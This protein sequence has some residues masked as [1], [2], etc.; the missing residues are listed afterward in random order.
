MWY[1]FINFELIALDLNKKLYSSNTVFLY[2][3]CHGKI[4]RLKEKKLYGKW[5][6]HQDLINLLSTL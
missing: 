5:L 3:K 4:V 6:P 2:Q 1:L